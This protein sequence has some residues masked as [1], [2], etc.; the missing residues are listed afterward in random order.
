ME[1]KN[2]IR[3]RQLCKN[4]IHI[5]NFSRLVLYARKIWNLVTDPHKKYL[6][7]S[8]LCENVSIS[9]F[10]VI[11]NIQRYFSVLLKLQEAAK[12]KAEE[13]KKFQQ[14]LITPDIVDLQQNVKINPKTE[15]VQKTDSIPPMVIDTFRNKNLLKR[16][17]NLIQFLE[18]YKSKFHQL[19]N[20]PRMK[21]FRFH[22]KKA[23]NLP[24][25]AISAVNSHHIIVSFE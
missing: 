6:K 20:D 11:V 1:N 10:L 16:Y 24:L 2:T 12:Q 14:K 5:F 22:C 4:I 18:D 8:L 15:G 9:L 21:Q 3:Q 25:N 23:V 13:Q 7:L 19:V 17:S